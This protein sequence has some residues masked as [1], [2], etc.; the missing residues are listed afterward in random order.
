M[1]IINIAGLVLIAAV[2]WWFWLYKPAKVNLDS[3][4]ITITV[5]NGVYQPPRI[6]VP[7]GKEI[8]FKFLRKDESP[9]AATVIFPELDVSGELPQN[10]LKTITLPPLKPGK[11]SFSCP[12]KM[13]KG[14]LIA[15]KN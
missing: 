6:S 7:A 3:D 1:I 15:V 10:K 11:Y 8:T 14:E 13:Y 12:M 4:E 5:E 9:C 2:V